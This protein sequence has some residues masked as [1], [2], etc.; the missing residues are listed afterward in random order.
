MILAR[1]TRRAILCTVAAAPLALPLLGCGSD[2]KKLPRVGFMPKL[3]GIPYFDGCLKGAREAAQE[4][5]LE[6]VYN[7]PQK[8]E[9]ELQ[10]P[11]LNSWVAG[12]EVDVICVACAKPE[13]L[14]PALKEARD[15]GIHVITYDADSLPEARDCFVN[16]ATYEGVAEMMVDEMVREIG[17]AGEVGILTSS[18]DAPNQRE[19]ARRMRAYVARR[20]PKINLLQEEEHGEESDPGI[21]RAK[22]LITTRPAMKGIIGLTSVSVPAAAEAVRQEKERLM[23]EGRVVKV[24]GVSTPR[25]MRDYVKSGV[26]EAFVLW[27]PIDLGYLAVHVA[28]QFRKGEGKKEGKITAGRLKEIA[29]TDGVALLGEPMRFTAENID[30]YDF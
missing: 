12:R 17:D 20:Y 14:V 22:T 13:P 5:N 11:L 8:A 27:N 21:S 18:V 1:P 15:A 6:L 16:Q 2:R 25:D 3:T 24:T 29:V 9:A 30:Q 10:I 23:K 26:V 7:G 28:D 19:W 4:L